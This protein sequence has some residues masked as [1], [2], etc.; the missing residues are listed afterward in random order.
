MKEGSSVSGCSEAPILEVCKQRLG[1]VMRAFE[2]E[3]GCGLDDL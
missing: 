3:L 2:H 1:F